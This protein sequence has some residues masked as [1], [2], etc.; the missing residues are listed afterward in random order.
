MAVYVIFVP[1]ALLQLGYDSFAIG[2]LLA[3]AP[4]VRFISPFLFV[5]KL[6]LS[7]KAFIY[8][9]VGS[10]VFAALF[11]VVIHSFVAT[12]VVALFFSL[13]WGLILPFVD[14]YA[15]SF[16]PKERY[17]KVR[18]F[19]SIGFMAAALLLGHFEPSLLQL[20]VVYLISIALAGIGGYACVHAQDRAAALLDFAPEKT[21][22]TFCVMSHWQL[23]LSMFLLQLS[24][25]AFY[26]FF[27][28][29]EVE[30][31]LS[32][33]RVTQLWA[34]GVACEIV[35]FMVQSPL[36]RRFDMLTLI[37]FTTAMTV[38]RWLLLQMFP[39]S[40]GFGLVSQAFHALNFALYTTAVFAYLFA[41]YE[42]KRVAQL[43]FYGISYGLGGF[44]GSLIS[45]AV[46]GEN[47]FLYAAFA[48]AAA[49]VVLI[50]YNGAKSA[51]RV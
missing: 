38:V 48:S 20:F 6:T 13:F 35:M 50:G 16:I 27:S 19:G 29:F 17:G 44:L 21:S 36:L 4:L 25:G 49:Y 42:D 40:L 46:Y 39:G 15:L 22:G 30:H 37:K 10:F 34:F 33:E 12:F 43:F 7:K 51:E 9:L 14:T 26:G 5:K 28:I 3:V 45:G 2:V 24:F 11:G 47:L 18:L 23:W 32:M 31:G 1:K 41:I 8:S